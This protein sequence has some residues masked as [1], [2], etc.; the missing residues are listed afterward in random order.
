[1]T[2]IHQLPFS[3][4]HAWLVAVSSMEQI[5]GAALS[6]IV[7]IV[8]PLL[9]LMLHPELSSAVQGVMGAAGLTGIAIGSAVIGT[10]S[11][12]YGYLLWFRVGPCLIIAGSI[13]AVLFP[14]PASI[15]CGLFLAGLGVGGGYPLDS[16]YISELMPDRWRGVMVGIAKASSAL[17][18]LLP[19]ALAVAILHWDAS[20]AAWRPVVGIM[21]VMGMITLLMR[22]R[23]AQSPAWLMARG[24]TSQANRAAAVFF[25]HNVVCDPSAATSKTSSQRMHGRFLSLL[26]GYN[27]VR[28]IYAGIPWACEGLGVY[29][30]G[31]FLPVLIMALGIGR[32][33]PSGIA[34]V[35]NSVELTAVINFCI[36]PGFVAGLFLARKLSYSLMMW[37]GFVGSAA[38]MA[39]LLAAYLLHLPVWVSVAGFILFEIL[40]NAGPHLVTYIIPTVVFPVE[41]R[42]AGSGIA[43][44]LGKAGAIVGVFF[45]PMMLRAGGMT[46]VLVVTIAVMLLGALVTVIFGRLLARYDKRMSQNF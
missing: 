3:G 19:A 31:V 22:C 21:G 24:L 33:E 34:G 2:Y 14:S 44:F 6:T 35:V 29:G 12:R 37:T 9:N 18:F 23:W 11:D 32:N 1:M 39:L 26:K 28:V 38:G 45:M 15:C 43:D 46:L 20:P 36:L 42:G 25:G 4:R 27:L 13:V 30:I 5:M 7:G 40:L 41:I 17:G 10:L 16:A 8:I